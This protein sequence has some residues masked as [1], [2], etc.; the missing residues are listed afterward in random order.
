[1]LFLVPSIALLG[2]TLRELTAESD[3]RIFPVCIC[4]DSEVSKRKVKD[5]EEGDGFTV[6]DLA[7]PAST[8]VPD[9]LLTQTS[10][11]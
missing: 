3:K 5:G 2:Q 10:F 9:I 8:H 1:V 11:L 4:S 6:E 7:L